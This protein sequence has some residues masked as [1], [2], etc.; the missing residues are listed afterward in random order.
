MTRDKL[1]IIVASVVV[2]MSLALGAV[3]IVPRTLGDSDEVAP[4]TQPGETPISD[5]SPSAPIV[6]IESMSPSAADGLALTIAEP[7]V[8]PDGDTVSYSYVW[9][10]DGV[11][12]PDLT[13]SIVASNHT[14]RGEVW[15]VEVTPS[16]GMDTGPIA[17]GEVTIQNGPPGA[18]GVSV[19]PSSPNTTHDLVL[20]IV[21]LSTD[22]DGDTVSYSYAWY[23]DGILQSDLTGSIVDSSYTSRGEM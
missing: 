2:L 3:A 19:E 9:Y 4:S 8:D 11:L 20:T 16:D 21:D 17:I 23:K 5:E 7:S 15:R 14:S 10:K 18:P 1:Q 13:E 22:P 12:Q 6:S